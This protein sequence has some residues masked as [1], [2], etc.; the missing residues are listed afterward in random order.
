MTLTLAASGLPP[1]VS[2]C[3]AYRGSLRRAWTAAKM[4]AM[5][6]RAPTA[7]TTMAMVIS[8]FML[9][10]VDDDAGGE[11]GHAGPA[12]GPQRSLFPDDF[13]DTFASK[14]NKGISVHQG[15][16]EMHN[17][18]IRCC[19]YCAHISWWYHCVKQDRHILS[20]LRILNLFVFD[21]LVV[22]Q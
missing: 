10:D 22:V 11:E 16:E 14:V 4:P 12:G 21:K 17:S 9:P 7:T 19:C 15:S 13:Q 18:R 2:V 1:S 20:L 5:A 6:R 3:P 8:T